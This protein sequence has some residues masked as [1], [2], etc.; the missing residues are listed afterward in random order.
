MNETL[1]LDYKTHKCYSARLRP[2][3]EDVRR[4]VEVL[5]NAQSPLMVVGSGVA[6]DEAVSE[7]VALA[8]S[9]GAGVYQTWPTDM[10]FPTNHQLYAGNL[11]LNNPVVRAKL[12]SADVVISIGNP[13]FRLVSLPDEPLLAPEAKMVQLDSDVWEMGKNMP[14]A[15]GVLGDIKV[16]AGKINDTLKI[17]LSPKERQLV[18]ERTKKISEEKNASIAALLEKAQ[19]EK[20]NVPIAVSRVMQEIA[21]CISPETIVIDD[22]WSNTEA[23]NNY[24]DFTEPGSYHR[25]REYRHGGGSI[26]WGIPVSLGIKL[27]CPDRPVV[28]VVGDGSAIFYFQSLWTAAHYNIPVVFIILANSSYNTLKK[29]KRAYLGPQEKDQVLGLDIND[30]KI[31]F[32]ELAQ[33]MG[34][35]GQRVEKPEAIKPALN[36]AMKSGKP[37]LVEI[38]IEDTV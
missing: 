23:L 25:I 3:P 28:A 11:R 35:Q 9:I 14:V 22:S 27:A 10:N 37:A 29:V 20:N 32:C 36:A 1:A 12:K 6:K 16:S 18:E 38:I 33:A 13:V 15:A 24:I 17:D 7:V 2:D 34:V 26:G 30:P 19:A 5:K 4:A 8:E 21:G 31:N